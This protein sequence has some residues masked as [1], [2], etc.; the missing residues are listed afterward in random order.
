MLQD[1][2]I[3]FS[4]LRTNQRI[5][6]NIFKNLV[7]KPCLFNIRTN[8]LYWHAGAGI[9]DPNTLDRQNEY[10]KKFGNDCNKAQRKVKTTWN[11]C[12]KQSRETIKETTRHHLEKTMVL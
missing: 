12:Q 4:M 10:I 9:D 1:L 5:Y 8:R 3:N 2:W 6:G 11:K 7:K